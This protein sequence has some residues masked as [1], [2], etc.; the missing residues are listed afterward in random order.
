[1]IV[2]ALRIDSLLIARNEGLSPS[3]S[4]AAA[5]MYAAFLSLTLVRSNAAA[6]PGLTTLVGRLRFGSLGVGGI[7]ETSS[8]SILLVSSV[9]SVSVF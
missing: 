7:S 3:D 1:M 2:L 6:K 4:A 9:E 5:M 8:A